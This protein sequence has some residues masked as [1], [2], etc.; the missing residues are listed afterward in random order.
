MTVNTAKDV[1]SID[2]SSEGIAL[3]HIVD[4]AKVKTLPVKTMKTPQLWQV[5]F[6]QNSKIVVSGSDHCIVYV[7]ERRDGSVSKLAA[8]G[9]AWVQTITVCHWFASPSWCDLIE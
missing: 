3:Y 7:F 4:G 8:E 2:D 9:T 6:T 5:A 1:F